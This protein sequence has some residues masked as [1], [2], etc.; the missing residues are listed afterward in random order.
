MNKK[1]MALAVAG[2]LAAPA[3]ALAQVQIGGSLTMFYYQH[4]P[5]N[6]S[7]GQS[8]DILEMSEPELYVR[9]SEKLGGGLEAWFQCTSSLDGMTGGTASAAG[10]CGRNSG[11]GFRGGFGN[12]F[13]GNWDQPQKLVFNAGRGWWGG[14]NALTGGSA[15]LLNGGSASGAANPVTTTAGFFSATSVPGVTTTTSNNPGTFFRRQAQSLNY[16]SPN[17]GGFSLQAGYSA[18]NE[19]TGIPEASPLT[20]RMYSVAGQFRTGPFYVGVGYEQHADYNPGNQAAYAGGDDNNITAVVGL[21]FGG[22]NIRGLY[23]R[24]EYEPTSTTSMDVDG[25]A[26]FGDFR[27][28]GAHTIRAQWAQVNDTGGSSTVAVG[29]YKG[30]A[31]ATCKTPGAPGSAASC[32]SDTGAMLYGVAYSYAFSKRTEGSVVYSVI[33]NDDKATFSKGK[34]AATA[35]SKQTTA[36]LVLKHSF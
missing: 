5:E 7:T 17:W 22:F 35:G 9:G 34:T 36:G 25:F 16:H 26:L 6:P 15:V 18:N 32:A 31:A 14:T 12:F 4:K 33:D 29:S 8:G 21:Q 3:A 20:P 19:S 1:V 28:A 30:S 23:S 13:G 27:F 2:V 10:W 24:S 11:L